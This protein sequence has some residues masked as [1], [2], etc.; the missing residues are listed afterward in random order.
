MTAPTDQFVT[1][2]QRGQ[3]ATTAA[4]RTWTESLKTYAQHYSAENPLPRPTE[5]HTVVDAWFDLTARLLDEQRAFVSTLVDTA[6]EATNAMQN[7]TRAVLEPVAEAAATA[8]EAPKRAR[9]ARN[10]ATD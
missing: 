8:A 6:T 4:V 2:A 3:E 9:T 10:G 5:V 1:I 7:Q